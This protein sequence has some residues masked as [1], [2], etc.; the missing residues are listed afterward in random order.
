MLA[1]HY[2]HARAVDQTVGRHY[3][4]LARQSAPAN[5]QNQNLG[6]RP[7]LRRG[8]IYDRI[9]EVRLGD[10]HEQHRAADGYA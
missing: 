6:R 2:P 4:A 5:K 1:S 7:R 3:R 10:I 9:R 8:L